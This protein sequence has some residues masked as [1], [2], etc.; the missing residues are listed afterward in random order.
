MYRVTRAEA[1]AWSK[2]GQQ[3]VVYVILNRINSRKFPDTLAEVIFQRGQ[4][5]VVSNGSW[6]RVE[7]TEELKKNV[8]EAYLNYSENNNANGALYFGAG[9]KTGGSHYLF[10]DEVGHVF[11]K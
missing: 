9:Q 4:F 6:N 7:I 3:N 5:A 11:Y 10:T 8:R 1:G 2:Q